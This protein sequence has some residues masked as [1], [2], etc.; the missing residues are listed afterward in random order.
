MGGILRLP[1]QRQQ[2]FRGHWDL[3][4]SDLPIILKEALALL[5]VLKWVARLVS[6][7][8]VDCLV[9]NASLVVCCKKDGS[10]NARVN[11]VVKEI[12]HLTLSANLHIILHFFPSEESPADYPSR[13]P[14]DLDCS[15]SPPS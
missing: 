6:I 8:R 1:S 4:E 7:A 12:F 15:L 11:N 3:H 2:E 14:S 5:F 9:D 10:R 13:V